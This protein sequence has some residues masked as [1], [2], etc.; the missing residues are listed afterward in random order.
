[1]QTFTV[2]WI[3]PLPRAWQWNG[4][5][6]ANTTEFLGGVLKCLHANKLKWPW[7][8]FD[9]FVLGLLSWADGD[10]RIPFLRGISWLLSFLN[11]VAVFFFFFK[12]KISHVFLSFA[13][14]HFAGNLIVKPNCKCLTY[15]FSSHWVAAA[16]HADQSAG[17]STSSIKGHRIIPFFFF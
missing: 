14:D 5:M 2:G 1:M 15:R 7:L 13:Q 6:A 12:K 8:E 10:C 16:G 9:L 11:F 3:A 17:K 4:F